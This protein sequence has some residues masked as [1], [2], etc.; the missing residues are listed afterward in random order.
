[1]EQVVQFLHEFY[2]AN[3]LHR[4]ASLSLTP[5]KNSSRLDALISVEALILPT[6][7]RVDRLASGHADRLA[8]ASIDDYAPIVQR[9]FFG[10]QQKRIDLASFVFLTAV[11]QAD[12]QPEASF[13]LRNVDKTLK[14]K[15]GETLTAG[16][17][18]G[19]IVQILDSEVILDTGGERWLLAVGDQLAE[20]L[21]LP[22]ES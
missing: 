15:T 14:L 20:A 13:T 2:S 4:I 6:T 3:H 21:A 10:F 12:G 17:V 7:D 11:T 18:T 8:W 22:P 9:N 1:M 5:V 16:G 19:T